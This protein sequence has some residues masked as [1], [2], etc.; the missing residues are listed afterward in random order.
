MIALQ[1]ECSIDKTKHITYRSRSPCYFYV[2]VCIFQLSFILLPALKSREVLDVSQAA[3][4]LVG[5]MIAA[6]LIPPCIYVTALLR[7][8]LK[9]VWGY[10]ARWERLEDDFRDELSEELGTPY[11]NA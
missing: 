1:R 7:G 2:S 10:T 3:S 6:I 8:E 9:E 11:I 4:T 5:G